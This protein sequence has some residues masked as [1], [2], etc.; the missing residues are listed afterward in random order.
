MNW[1]IAQ[2]RSSPSLICSASDRGPKPELVLGA[3]D[4]GA[5]VRSRH[6]YVGLWAPSHSVIFFFLLL[7]LGY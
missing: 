5:L 6:K 3:P 1:S 2:G 4:Q 7:L